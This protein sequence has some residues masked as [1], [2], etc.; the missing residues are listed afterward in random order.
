MGL[1]RG[2]ETDFLNTFSPHYCFVGQTVFAPSVADAGLWVEKLVWRAAVCSCKKHD[3]DTEGRVHR[4]VVVFLK[5]K[6][7][8]AN[9]C[10]HLNNPNPPDRPSCPL[11]GEFRLKV[12]QVLVG[13]AS[14]GPKDAVR[15]GP[16]LV[17]GRRALES[18]DHVVKHVHGLH[19]VFILQV[20]F[21]FKKKKIIN[22][23]W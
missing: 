18:L 3:P 19:D 5:E 13:Q 14:S 23:R 9:K 12:G 6:L 1:S 4:A 8:L 7:L 15:Y 16:V 21:I 11:E 17:P 2:S 10:A 22:F 20:R